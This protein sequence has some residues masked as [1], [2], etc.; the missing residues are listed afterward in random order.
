M[1]REIDFYSEAR[2]GGL[3]RMEHGPDHMLEEFKDREDRLYKRYV[4]MLSEEEKVSDGM[5]RSVKVC[6]MLESVL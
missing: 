6:S 2:Y 1:Q 3:K 4:K 5:R